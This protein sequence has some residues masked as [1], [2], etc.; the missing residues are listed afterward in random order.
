MTKS[1]VLFS[2]NIS[3]PTK[4]GTT[5]IMGVR[6][7]MGTRKYLGFPSMI[8][9]SKKVTFS[10]IKDRIWNKINSLR[11]RSLSKEFK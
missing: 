2:R 3:N 1:E 5:S 10:F 9:R 8:E 7:V 11:C 4:E 6:R